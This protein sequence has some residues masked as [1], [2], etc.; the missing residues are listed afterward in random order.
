M[1]TSYIVNNSDNFVVERTPPRDLLV[2]SEILD[3]IPS[4]STNFFKSPLYDAT[5]RKFIG[6]CPRNEGMS[7]KPSV[8]NEFGLSSEAKK[9]DS[10]LY[11]IQYKLS[12]LT[13]PIVKDYKCEG[14][15][16]IK[17]D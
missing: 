3:A 17:K 6:M 13:R 10:K 16:T 9:D 8:F 1:D 2:Y 12:G 4:L 7:Y 15:I 11:D 14:F 5:R